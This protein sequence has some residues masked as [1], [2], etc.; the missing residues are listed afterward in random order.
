MLALDVSSVA[1]WA[2]GLV[3]A[4]G[5][6][7]LVSVFQRAQQL[8][9]KLRAIPKVPSSYPLSHLVQLITRP[10]W[11]VME[12]W[13]RQHGSVVRFHLFNQTYV[14]VADP[15]VLKHVL[16]SNI[17]NYEKD[18]D[19]Y[20]PFL[21]VLGTGLVTSHGELWRKQRQLLSG[22]FR[23][24]I[25]AD[26]ASVAIKATER[27]SRMLERMRGTGAPVT[28]GEEFRKLTLQ[29][30]GEAVL[31]LAPDECDAF[32]PHV[33][34]PIVEEANKRT[35][36]PWRAYLPTKGNRD[37][38][39]A[40]KQLNHYVT[41]LVSKRAA[42]RLS[43]R[44]AKLAAARAA[45]NNDASAAAESL[46]LQGDILDRILEACFAEHDAAAAAPASSDSNHSP[47]LTELSPE[48]LRQLRDEIK[49]FVFA[50]H[51]TSSM[52]ITWTLYQLLKNPHCLARVRAEAAAV[53]GDYEAARA[54][55]NQSPD[56]PP[57][58][59]YAG[60]S[61]T[62]NALR[63][64]LRL[65]SIVPVVTRHVVDDDVVGDYFLPRDSKLVLCLQSVHHNDAYWEAP[66]EYRPERFESNYH[67][68]AFLPFINGPRRCVG[69]FFALLETKIVLALL[70]HR[71]NFTI[72]PG[73]EGAKHPFNIPVCPADALPVLVD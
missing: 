53:F 70:V 44:A 22:V 68:Y 15:E 16:S 47:P 52:M 5:V 10:P 56:E 59:A 24:E 13:T 69:Q 48:R 7:W 63:E 1:T 18:R 41:D 30:I 4:F 28:I 26:T 73:C 14:V 21:C 66:Y 25:L 20:A 36:Y 64:A 19:T 45:N 29:V 55:G 58:R 49:T 51:E 62:Q 33:Y 23:E 57:F 17:H 39:R 71:F 46:A 34:L 38:H 60:L 9:H 27:L 37:Y 6:Y 40:I 67:P 65:Y 54:A 50:G 11:D 42:L 61:Y 3:V 2:L 8:D 35:W 43:E 12:Q 72:A 32:F 31:S